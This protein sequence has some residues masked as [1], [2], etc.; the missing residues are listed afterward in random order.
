MKTWV[1][2]ALLMFSSYSM[3]ALL[4]LEPGTE[5]I[6]RVSIAKKATASIDGQNVELLPVGAGLRSKRVLI[7][8]VK[9]YVNQILSTQPEK[10]NHDMNLAL[11]ST[12][13]MQT[14]AVA[15]TFLRTVDADKIQ[16]AFVDSFIANKIDPK[17]ASIAQFLANV[18]AGGDAKVGQTL[19]F[20]LTQNASGTDSIHYEDGNG[21]AFVVEGPRGLAQKIL[22]LWLGTPADDGLAKLKKQ[23]LK[24]N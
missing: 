24:V 21:K 3:A 17:D 4:T 9:V 14:V 15:L 12:E 7:A 10:L 8:D 11:A 23:I 18:K 1:V 13:Q 5:A 2:S 6:E 20:V 16:M 22:A 19:S